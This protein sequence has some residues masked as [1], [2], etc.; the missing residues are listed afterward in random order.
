MANS[1]WVGPFGI[2]NNG[3]QIVFP[4]PIAFPDGTSAAPGAVFAS[5]PSLGFYRPTAAEIY[6]PSG[7]VFGVS[8]N[9]TSGVAIANGNI[10]LGS[11]AQ[12]GWTAASEQTGQDTIIVRD[13]ANILALKNG[14]NQQAL[15]VYGNGSTGYYLTLTG[16]GGSSLINA[17]GTNSD[18]RI[19][20]GDAGG[21]GLFLSGLNSVDNQWQ[22]TSAGKLIAVTDNSYDIGAS[23]ATRPATIYAGT[24]VVAP[25]YTAGASAG[26]ANFGPSVVTS[27]TI[28]GGIVTAIS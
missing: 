13:A 27:I 24:R 3:T 21:S 20:G 4:L 5:E 2:T 22:I 7:K 19:R 11:A 9:T 6:I 23:G 28:V 15:R 14:T 26:V 17:V 8:Y 12:F 18:L 1:V 10:I 25:A 16:S